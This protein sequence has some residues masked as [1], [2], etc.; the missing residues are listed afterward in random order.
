M[1]KN[2]KGIYQ[3]ET[4]LSFKELTHG[5]S[6]RQFGDMS[7]V[8]IKADNTLDAFTNA[9]GVDV[10]DIVLMEQVHGDTIADVVLSDKRSFIN[11]TDGLV[12]GDKKTFLCVRT[13]DCVP[14]LAYDPKHHVVGVAHSGWKGAMRNIAAVLVLQMV[15]KGADAAT[16]VIGLGPSIRDCCYDIDQERADMFGLVFPDFAQYI[17]KEKNGA[18]YLSLQELISRQLQKVGV[19][20]DHIE[21]SMICTKDH[22]DEFYSYRDKEYPFGLFAGIIGMR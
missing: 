15:E 14:I 18:V 2:D 22:S 4:L 19:M 9:L 7:T 12:N 16:L 8:W 5:F 10:S 20:K 13:G 11:K 21:D 3:F 1:I 6:T 17:L